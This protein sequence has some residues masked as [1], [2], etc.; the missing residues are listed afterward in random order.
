MLFRIWHHIYLTRKT[1]FVLVDGATISWTPEPTGKY[2]DVEMPTDRTELSDH[3]DKWCN[4]SSSANSNKLLPAQVK[5]K[6]F[7]QFRTIVTRL[8]CGFKENRVGSRQKCR[9]HVG[10]VGVLL[11]ASVGLRA[12]RGAESPRCGRMMSNCIYERRR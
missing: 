12:R 9:S 7:L 3:F 2:V 6:A 10:T 4:A 1:T 11:P 5:S 8:V